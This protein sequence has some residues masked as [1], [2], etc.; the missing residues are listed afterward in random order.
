MDLRVRHIAT[1]VVIGGVGLAILSSIS[2][3]TIPE[4][5]QP[6][7]DRLQNSS[8]ASVDFLWT[9][10]GSGRQ[11]AGALRSNN[12]GKSV[13]DIIDGP[14]ARL[15]MIDGMVKIITP[16]IKWPVPSLNDRG[17][18]MYE[19]LW[20]GLANSDWSPADP[21]KRG[22]FP[23]PEGRR[24]AKLKLTFDWAAGHEIILG[25]NADDGRL[26][27]VIVQALNRPS[28]SMTFRQFRG[29]PMTLPLSEGP[30]M[31]L[32][33]EDIRWNLTLSAADL[34]PAEHP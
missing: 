16:D 3:P 21:P 4:G 5:F 30:Q 27:T 14:R 20:T 18:D 13:L 25:V 8:S 26:R 24:W 1:P 17:K 22:M 10:P 12:T 23:A 31:W 11:L 33:I 7:V 34:D 15:T 19:E 29:G 2:G 28:L 9:E 32:V 6:L